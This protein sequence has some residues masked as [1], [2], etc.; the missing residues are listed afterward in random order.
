MVKDAI[1]LD[2]EFAIDSGEAERVLGSVLSKVLTSQKS[3][4]DK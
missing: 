2:I 3:F 1:C 4:P